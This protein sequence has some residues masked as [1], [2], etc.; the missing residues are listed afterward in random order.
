EWAEAA[1]PRSGACDPGL[2]SA[3]TVRR[4]AGGRPESRGGIA[5]VS[6]AWVSCRA[7]WRAIGERGQRTVQPK[8]MR[9][10]AR[11]EIT[12]ELDVAMRG[13]WMIEKA[14]AADGRRGRRP[15]SASEEIRL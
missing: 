7:A 10:L 14:D 5:L 1:R 9:S 3:S 13:G 2:R 4:R 15:G 12:H 8:R 6:S 11:R